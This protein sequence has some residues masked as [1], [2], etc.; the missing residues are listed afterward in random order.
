M[1]AVSSRSLGEDFVE[2]AA[3]ADNAARLRY[4]ENLRKASCVVVAWHFLRLSGWALTGSVRVGR[5]GG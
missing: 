3:T 2:A 5:A 1:S 4:F